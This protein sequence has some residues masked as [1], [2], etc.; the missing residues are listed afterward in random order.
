MKI[1][2]M[3][4]TQILLDFCCCYDAQEKENADKRLAK[5]QHDLLEAQAALYEEGQ[6]A[7]RLQMELDAKESEIEQLQQKVLLHGSDSTSVHSDT[8]PEGTTGDLTC[9][10]PFR[11]FD[12][13]TRLSYLL[14]GSLDFL[15]A[16]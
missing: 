1:P 9:T 13:F 16:E 5:L 11:H 15:S 12:S 7:Q 4:S 8:D 10:F 2:E 14:L 6:R 3:T